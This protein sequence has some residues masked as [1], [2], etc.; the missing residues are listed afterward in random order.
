MVLLTAQET[1]DQRQGL[2]PVQGV[3]TA[4]LHKAGK[5]KGLYAPRIDWK[6]VPVVAQWLA[7]P[8]RNHE[9]VGSIRGLIQLVKD[10]ALL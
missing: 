5:L 9:V 6:G 1:R 8:T 4:I 10:L 2:G 3:G 7:N